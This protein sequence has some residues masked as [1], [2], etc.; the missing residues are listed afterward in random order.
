[1]AKD[2]PDPGYWHRVHARTVAEVRDAAST[3]TTAAALFVLAVPV[4]KG[5]F[6]VVSGTHVDEAFFGT[7]RFELAVIA[8][9]LLIYLFLFFSMPP[10]MEREATETHALEIERAVAE[11]VAMGREAAL[12]TPQLKV[13]RTTSNGTITTTIDVV[14]DRSEADLEAFRQILA[15]DKDPG[16]PRPDLLRLPEESGGPRT[17]EPSAQRGSVPIYPTKIGVFKKVRRGDSLTPLP[18]P[19]VIEPD[20]PPVLPPEV[21]P[22]V[23]P[24]T[25]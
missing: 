15:S 7:V 10:K 3:K 25:S 11:A 13:A 16:E 20:E 2:P 19:L 12:P 22:P 24:E 18:G 9:A 5:A 8:A 14:G 17:E 1:M 6:D 23:Y 21:A 4:I